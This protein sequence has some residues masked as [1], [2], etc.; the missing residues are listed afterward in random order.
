[1]VAPAFA[2]GSNQPF[3][4]S[5]VPSDYE[6][7]V[8]DLS[9]GRTEAVAF[10]QAERDQQQ[11]FRIGNFGTTAPTWATATLLWGLDNANGANPVLPSDT[12]A[13]LGA[14]SK[15][16]HVGSGQRTFQNVQLSSPLLNLLNVK[17]VIASGGDGAGTDLERLDPTASKSQFQP[18]FSDFYQIFENRAVLPRALVVPR[19]RVVADRAEILDLLRT[20]KVDP[21]AEVLLERP[22][23]AADRGDFAEI[24]GPPSVTYAAAGFNRVGVYVE[25]SPAG[26]LLVL[27]PYSPDWTATIDG[28]PTEIYRADYLFRAIKLTPGTHD[29]VMSYE[30]KSVR[31]GLLMTGVAALLSA[32]IF[33]RPVIRRRSHAILVKPGVRALAGLLVV[34]AAYASLQLQHP[35]LP[36]LYYDE[37]IQV[38]PALDVVRGGLWSSVNWTPSADVSLLGYSLP[39]MTM[40]YIGSLKTMLFIP[41]V[42]AAG[43]TPESVR[44]T[45]VLIGA[46]SLLAVFAFAR[47]VAGTPV[48]LITVAL[49]ATDLSFIYYVRVDY[50]PT[51]LMLLLK[52]IALWQLA[53]W[54]QT[55]RLRHL[56]V[57]ALALGLGVYNKADFLW[58]VFGI[59]GAAVLVSLGGVRARATPR[60]IASAAAAFALGAAPLIYFN[61]WWSMPT[62]AALSGPATASGLSGGFGD[63]FLERLGVLEHLLDA[64]H[65][66]VGQVALAPTGGLVVWL[67]ATSALLAV[68]VLARERLRTLSGRNGRDNSLPRVSLF[69]LTATLLILAAA[70]ATPG[71]FAGHHVILTYPLPHLLAATG[72]VIVMEWVRRR[73][74]VR[75]ATGLASAAC[76]V[77]AGQNWLT[78][79]AYL[80][81]LA[82]TGGAGNFSDAIYRLADRLE[83][84]QS[85]ATVIDLDW[86]FHFPL[87]GLS[88]G[89]IHSVEMT[90][91]SISELRLYLADPSVKYIAH[92]PGANNL[93]RGLEAFNAAA[94]AAGLE[95]VREQR[96]TTRDGKPAIDVYVTRRAGQAS[97]SRP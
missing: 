53:S 14:M 81:R 3:N 50:G 61:L 33:L 15:D 9:G 23:P 55:N 79:D 90:D 51:A 57:G 11:P 73:L 43:I 78:T 96:F 46:A 67:S 82:V 5:D 72:I 16:G 65:V 94:K 95:V 97:A 39:L 31:W 22:S 89:S 30:P 2:F 87:V 28:M 35:R 37:L 68:T 6:L 64:G 52:S 8:S 49:L 25:N 93:P 58:I 41:I 70:A 88:Q 71:G 21:R 56:F 17:Y 62:L 24:S 12:A 85:G 69:A 10:L 83:R 60:S 47:R 13:F 59:V 63:Q 38:V 76:V 20:G 18:V 75:L 86:G 4:T 91:G 74:G 27:D 19:P 1:V 80:N 92:A 45:T 66:S 34:L 44:I 36:G 42:A 26:F 54:W 77:A 32:G 84:D 29:I 48:A 7:G 40:D